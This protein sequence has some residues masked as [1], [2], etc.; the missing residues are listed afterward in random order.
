MRSSHGFATSLVIDPAPSRLLAV[1]WA[2]GIAAAGAALTLLA[3]TWILPALALL[4]GGSLLEWRRLR[5]L[6]RLE[7][8]KDGTWRLATARGRCHAQLQAGSFSTPWVVVLVLTTE[9]GTV[10]HL[11][12]C[13]AVDEH[14]WRHLRVRLQLQGG[15][16]TE[17]TP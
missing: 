11:L 7:W 4:I 3:A 5:T 15:S 12:V 16:A 17:S 2:A 14:T 9:R 1:G 6:G 8:R 10:R 13:D